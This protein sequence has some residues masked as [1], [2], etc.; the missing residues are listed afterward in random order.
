[1]FTKTAHTTTVTMTYTQQYK[2]MKHQTYISIKRH[3]ASN[4]VA[5][6]S[7]TLLYWLSHQRYQT[8]SIKHHAVHIF[9]YSSGTLCP[10]SR[11]EASVLLK[12]LELEIITDVSAHFTKQAEYKVFT[13]IKVHYTTAHFTAASCTGND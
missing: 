1:M 12:G 10:W 3:N 9:F 5:R 6:T 2:I 13:Q 11:S 8:T 7:C 4:N